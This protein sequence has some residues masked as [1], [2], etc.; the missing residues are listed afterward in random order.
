MTWLEHVAVVEERSV[1]YGGLVVKPE[2]R[3]K[4]RLEDN[5]KMDFQKIGW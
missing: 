1:E 4:H 5:I 3:P 2:G